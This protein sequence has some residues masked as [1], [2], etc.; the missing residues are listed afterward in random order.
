MLCDLI[1]QLWVLWD[2]MGQLWDVMELLGHLWDIMGLIHCNIISCSSNL[3]TISFLRN[4]EPYTGDWGVILLYVERAVEIV[5]EEELDDSLYDHTVLYGIFLNIYL[6]LCNIN[7]RSVFWN[8]PY[9]L[10]YKKLLTNLS[11]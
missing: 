4:V 3:I 9:I 2:L 10:L 6:T 11:Q 8:I 1:G 5:L 7:S